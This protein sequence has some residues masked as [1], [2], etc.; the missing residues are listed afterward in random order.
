MGY[1]FNK[2]HNMEVNN[3]QSGFQCEK[4]EIS[5]PYVMLYSKVQQ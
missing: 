1:L 4:Q 5:V 3:D 2:S